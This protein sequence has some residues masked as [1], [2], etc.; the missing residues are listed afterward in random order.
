MNA[1]PSFTDHEYFVKTLSLG[2][3][4]RAT[5]C[6]QQNDGPCPL[7]AVANVLLL[8]NRLRIKDGVDRLKTSHL[9]TLI[10]EHV[11]SHLEGKGEGNFHYTRARFC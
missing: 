4:K 5:I 10:G 9:L 8:K 2:N 1:E 11:T 6:L 3:G 7:L